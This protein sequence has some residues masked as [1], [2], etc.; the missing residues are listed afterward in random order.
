MK[1]RWLMVTKERYKVGSVARALRLVDLIAAA[2]HN[3]LTLSDLTKE[4]GVSKSTVFALL[5]TLMEAGYVRQTKPGPRYLPGI[6]L[7]RLGDLAG[8]HLPFGEVA[9]PIMHRLS[10]ATGLT[11]RASV[12]DG[13]HPVFV[14]RVD[15]PGNIRFLTLLGARELPHVSSAGKAM[16]A[17]MSDADIAQVIEQTGLPK[18]TK[19]TRTELSQLMNDIRRIRATGYAIDDEEDDVGVFCVGAAFFDHSGRCVGAISAT[20]IKREL[21]QRAVEQLGRQVVDAAAEITHALGG[22]IRKQA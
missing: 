4:L 15:A 12:N 1:V 10:R 7:V 21:S 2:P 6:S 11:I 17:Q 13:G 19:N 18:R 22:K 9:Q 14:S 8:G 16:L 3:G 5:Q 20:G